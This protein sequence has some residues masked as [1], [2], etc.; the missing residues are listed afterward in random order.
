MKQE[1]RIAI[2][3]RVLEIPGFPVEEVVVLR[4]DSELLVVRHIHALGRAHPGLHLRGLECRPAHEGPVGIGRCRSQ[5]LHGLGRVAQIFPGHQV[6]VGIVVHDRVV[7]IRAGDGVDAEL[8]AFCLR[9]EA[10]VRPQARRFHQHLGAVIPQERLVAGRLH[11]LAQ[12]IHDVGIDM[13]LRGPGG[14]V[15][16]RF[17]PVDGAPRE[18][19]SSMPQLPG[20]CPRLLEHLVAEGQQV[21]GNARR[22]IG[23][24]RQHVDFG[25]PEVMPF[26]GLSGE[27]LRRDTGVFRPR[28]GLQ[29][30]K[31]VE[32][33][34]LLDF[35]GAALRAVFPAILY[36]DV[37]AL[38]EISHVLLL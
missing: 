33:D 37:A 20:A 7:F 18:H 14:V 29:D 12:R 4:D 23:Q 15:G 31:E 6:G 24:E 27:A 19:G 1:Q 38:P 22:G 26:I 32:A 28:R 17:F 21:P 3:W 5:R 8:P 34:R 16:R 9:V 13:I 35:H 36:L 25:V 10:E 2:G 11:V 30:V